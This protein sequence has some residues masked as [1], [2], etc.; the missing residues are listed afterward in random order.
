M[1]KFYTVNNKVHVEC[2]VPVDSPTLIRSGDLYLVASDPFEEVKL[3]WDRDSDVNKLES[4][5]ENTYE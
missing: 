2:V 4:L 1:F 5:E 3:E